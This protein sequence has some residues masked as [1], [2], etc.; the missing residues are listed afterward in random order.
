MT[1]L[2]DILIP[3]YNRPASLAVTLAGLISQSFRDFRVTIS[4]QTEFD[5]AN[6]C[7]QVI[8]V[9]RVL[10]LHNNPVRFFNNLPNQGMAQQRQFLLD[11]VEAPY[12]LFLDDDLMLENY[13]VENMVSAIQAEKCGFVGCALA[14]LSFLEDMRPQEQLIE[15]WEGP[16]R[17]EAV[18]PGSLAWERHKLHNAANILH[19]SRGLGI[20]PEKPLKYRVAWVGGC[21]MY[22]TAKLRSVGGFSFWKD[23]PRQHAGEDVLA[24]LLVMNKY[25][26]CG[27]IPS[28]VYH[29]ELPTTLP[30]RKVDAPKVLDID[31]EVN[32]S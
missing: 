32:K 6:E 13:V 29:Q 3:T 1:P 25:G 30:D 7:P 10:A 17:P 19:A 23:L 26:G 20:S 31:I 22:D 9:T 5:K 16:V 2:V 4:D 11:Q 18:R 21:V 28:G 12:A 24:Q 15:F 14:G 8:A 27:L